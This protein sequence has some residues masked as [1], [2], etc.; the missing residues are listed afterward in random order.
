MAKNESPQHRQTPGYQRPGIVHKGALKQF[1]GSPL[2]QQ[3]G[4]GLPGVPGQ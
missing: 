1:A 2:G 3:K 4:I